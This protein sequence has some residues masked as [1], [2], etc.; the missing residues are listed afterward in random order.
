M[1]QKKAVTPFTVITGP[2]GSGKS[3]LAI[4]LALKTGGGI[5]SCD[6][7]Q[8]YKYMDIGTAKTPVEL[9]KGVGHFMIDVAEPDCDYSVSL[10]RDGADR[11]AELLYSEGKSVVAAG[12]TGLY[13]KALLYGHSF[14]NSAKDEAVRAEYSALLLEKGKEYLYS[15]LEKAD[16][17]AAAGLHQNDTKRV[18]RAL[19]IFRAGGQTKSAA[20][21]ADKKIAAARYPYKIFVLAIDRDRLYNRTNA[22][23]DRMIKDGLAEETENLLKSGYHAGLNS[24][25]AIGYAEMIRYLQGGLKKEEAV[26][27]IKQNTRRY[28]KRQITFCKGFKD[29]VRLDAESGEKALIGEIMK[30]VKFL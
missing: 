7:M 21:I 10:F 24:M 6:S 29:A 18:I 16:P 30:E 26:E 8:I 20:I 4:E 14:G 17:E 3:E 1:V 15:L 27:L 22:R 28:A 5:I 12:G 13:I 11:A 23:V 25:K 9:R 19:E 2:T